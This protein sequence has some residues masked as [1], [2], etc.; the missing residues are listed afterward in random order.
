MA[1]KRP[2]WQID[3]CPA[4]CAGGHGEHD[5]LDDRVHRSV[6]FT[7]PVVS[8]RV[9]LDGDRFG[10]VVEGAEF[11]IGLSRRDGEPDTWFY[12][13]GGPENSVDVSVES[14]HRL[15]RSAS[16]RLGSVE[17]DGGGRSGHRD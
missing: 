15:L 3:S 11:E 6:A 13:G 14:A 16:I 10:Y 12:L 4:W 1:N 17:P 2:T 8:R 5:H 9:R 7:V